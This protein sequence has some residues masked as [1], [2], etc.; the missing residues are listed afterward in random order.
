MSFVQNFQWPSAL[1]SDWIW[2]T[3]LLASFCNHKKSCKQD[4]SFLNNYSYDPN[5]GLPITGFGIQMPSSWSEYWIFSLLIK[6]WAEY[7][8]TN[9][10]LITWLNLV[11][12]SGQFEYTNNS[13]IIILLSKLSPFWHEKC[14]KSLFQPAVGVHSTQ[15]V[16]KIYNIGKFFK[17]WQ[18]VFL[19]I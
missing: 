10:G 17:N 8:S 19:L 12:Y 13:L 1:R 15:T 14:W 11:W 4:F 9:P 2:F 6:S 18:T 7:W 3:H 16:V 5:T